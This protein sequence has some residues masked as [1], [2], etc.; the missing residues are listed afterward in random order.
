MLRLPTR[1]ISHGNIKRAVLPL[2]LVLLA[3]ACNL[4]VSVPFLGPTA[5]PSPTPTPT[6]IPTP[7]PTLTPT[8]TPTPVPAARI[9]EGDQALFY[10]DYE[11]AV[12]DFQAAQQAS[13]DPALQ[14]AAQLGIGRALAEAGNPKAAV[15][16]LTAFIQNNPDSNELPYAYFTLAQAYMSLERYSE[17]AEAY[18]NYL[19]NRPGVVDAYI[20]ELR[21]DALRLAG[22]NPGAIND[23]RAAISSPS[24]LNPLLIEIKIGQAYLAIGD[25][26]NALQMFADVYNQASTDFTRAQMDVLMA[27]AYI[28]LG[29]ADQAYAAYQDA[30]TNFPTV[31]DAYTSLLALV[32]AGVPVNELNRGIV[33]YYA[34]QYGVA[35]AALDRYLQD[36][37]PDPAAARYFAGLTQ[38]ALG[39]Y[40]GALEQWDRVINNYPDD[41]YAEKAYEQKA[42]TQWAYLDKFPEAVQTL[43]NFVAKYPAHPRAAEF[44]YDAASVAEQDD[45]LTQAAEL[46]ERVSTEYPVDER[47][48]RALLLAGVSRY[49]LADYAGAQ[50]LFQRLLGIAVSLD[51]RAAAYFWQGKALNAGGDRAGAQ[52]AWEQASVT[53][54]TGYYSERARDVLRNRAPFAP[55]QTL[56]LTVDLPTERA[57]AEEWLRATFGL[58]EA[59]DLSSPGPLAA[60]PRLIRGTELWKLGLLDD[61]RAEFEALRTEVQ[62]DAANSY[63][64]ANYL[65]TVGSYRQAIQAARQVLTLAGLDDAATLNAPAYF[66]HLRFGTYFSDLIIPQAQANGFD[67]LFLFSVVR[68]ESA[69]EGFVRSSA[70]ARGLM[71][72]MPAT[73]QEIASKSG[74]PPDY[75]DDD[76]YRP[77]INIPLGTSYLAT[78]RDKLKGDLYAA[79]AAYN[80]GPGNATAWHAKAPDDPD[81][82]LE[83]VS[84]EE[85]RTYIRSVYENY[86]LYRKI[87][88]RAP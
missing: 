16:T 77:Y 73:G 8:P 36:N 74:W 6:E 7:T 86:A 1:P 68:Q 32:E 76:L 78:W 11:R 22:D 59:T 50:A 51:Q 87:Y 17:A 69:F 18:F 14:I 30:V 83:I 71:Q 72:I 56:D 29:Q 55:I 25:Y 33:D 75:T 4:P 41:R 38:R 57:R 5:T 81:L 48:Y 19:A 20:L 23:Y 15:E 34:G 31:Y 54:P 44:L 37:P 85:T 28:G 79:L 35:L 70:G 40:D 43:L 66:N 64:L 39:G 84:Y 80:G 58:G 24:T 88:E 47:A 65:V 3:V 45:N 27:Q 12:S 53:D 67:P 49:R 61:A 9:A 52:T 42:Y 2:L 60:D 62:G 10:G 46:W 82:F 26:A 13:T 63:R 21:G